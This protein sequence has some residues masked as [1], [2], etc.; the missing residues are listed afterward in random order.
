MNLGA[1]LQDKV[2]V[3]T[4]S[5]RGIG[6]EAARQALALGARV[7]LNGR[8]A[9]ALEATRSALAPSDRILAV[10]ADV[11]RPE[12]ASRLVAQVLATWGRVDVVINNAGLSM[13]G[14]FADLS[15]TTVQAMVEANLL[16]A[17]W[18]TKAALPALRESRGRVLFVSSLAGLRG[19][20][21]V[22]LYSATKM[23]LTALCQSLRAEE[24]P[25]GVWFGLI[26]L[27]FTENDPAKTVL[28]ADGHP[29]RHDRRWALSQS[30]TARALLAAVARRRKTTVLTPAGKALAIVQSLFPGLMDGWIGATGGRLHHVEAKK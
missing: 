8:D 2:I 14:A 6:R 1:S 23:A 7:V 10:A 26:S 24:G 5:A 4:G 27:A 20:P 22:S 17:V 21:G 25:R 13:R 9:E 11:S 12:E 28:G 16:T 30:Q 19:F 18:M 15:P 3:I 29:F